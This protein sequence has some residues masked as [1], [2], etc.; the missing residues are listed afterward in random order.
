VLPSIAGNGSRRPEHLQAGIF[1]GKNVGNLEGGLR[2]KPT[3]K[4]HQN[5]EHFMHQCWLV[6]VNQQKADAHNSE[7]VN[8]L[9]EKEKRFSGKQTFLQR[10]WDHPNTTSPLHQNKMFH[11]YQHPLKPARLL[12]NFFKNTI[13]KMDET[14]PEKGPF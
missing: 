11:S 7:P 3:N 2:G 4:T 14:S 1:S 13:P 5:I 9:Q 12:K 6:T 10:N 8:H